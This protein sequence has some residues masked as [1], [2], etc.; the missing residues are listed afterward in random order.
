MIRE[1]ILQMKLGHVHRDY[2]QNKFGVDIRE[3]FAGSVSKLQDKG[4][5]EPDSDSLRL[6]RDGLLQ[7]DRLLYEFFLPQ[8]RDARYA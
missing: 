6:K 2:F 5:L 8:H 1:L 4:F 3:R 7:V